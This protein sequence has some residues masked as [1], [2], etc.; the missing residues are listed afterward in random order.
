[1]RDS[2]WGGARARALLHEITADA[3]A[4]AGFK[5]GALEV[6]RPQGLLEF[7]AITGEPEGSA[8]LLGTGSRVEDMIAAIDDGVTHGEWTFVAEDAYSPGVEE[9]LRDASWVPD[10]PRTDD[11]GDW[12]P[13]DMLVAEVR[14]EGGALR[15]LLYLDEPFGLRRLSRTRFEALTDTLSLTL[16]TILAVIEREEFAHLARSIRAARV[17]VQS[18]P[19]RH[20]VGHLLREARK[21]LVEALSVDELEIDV[22]IAGEIETTDGLSLELDLDVRRALQAAAIRAWTQPNRV[23]IIEPGLVWGDGE[24]EAAYA[25]WFTTALATAG[26][27]TLVVAPVGVDDQVLGMIV[28]ARRTG[29]RR[30]T[31]GE[32]LAALELGHDLG[33]ALANAHATQRERRLLG[34]LRELEE[35]RYRFL[36]ELTH[37]INNPMTVIAANAEFLATNDLADE[38]D[39]KRAQAILRGTERL[40]DLLD[41]LAMLSRVS[42]PQNAPALEEVDLL[43][44]VEDTISSMAAV[45][46]RAGITLHLVGETGSTIVLADSREISSAVANLVDNAVKYSDSGDEIWLGVERRDDGGVTFTCRDEGIGISDADQVDLFDPLFRSTNEEALMR[47]GTGLGLGIV[48]QIMQRIGGDVEVESVLGRGTTVRLRFRA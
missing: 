41:G 17:M 45:A 33:R 13:L 43:G 46:E 10:I 48:R 11:D 22:F 24:V 7:V 21:A 2:S 5:V 3:A 27:E 44:V 26:F 18:S 20:D 15:A 31:D 37:E 28:C 30:W 19:A 23:V 32:S 36:R 34:E 42:D 38:R 9:A 12:H 25:D 6:V 35:S 4:R 47:P 1:M 16:G 14:D 8:Q 39:V 29:S 40:G